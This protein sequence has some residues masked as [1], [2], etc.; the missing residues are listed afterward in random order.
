MK[1]PL[2]KRIKRE[3]KQDMGKHIALFL[4]LCLTIG[5]CSGFIVADGSM[6][7]TYND[8]FEKY[9]VED[10]HFSLSLPAD[11]K[12]ISDLESK[13]DITIYPLFYKDVET[14]DG[15]TV[16][17]Y[18]NRDKVN[19]VDVLEGELPDHNEEIAIDRL[20]A[21]NN[22]LSTGDLIRFGNKDFKI[23][24]LVALTD[25]SALFKNNTDMMLNAQ[26]FAVSVVNDNAFEDIITAIR[27]IAML[28]L[29]TTN[30]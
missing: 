10:G 19:L 5:F 14:K 25:Y 3:L 26:N 28:G 18:K 20:F 23:S 13:E 12:L 11:K 7:R 17:I 21:E 29:T 8:S 27:C 24:G 30:H 6:N 2:Y 9:N 1:N 16:R 4:F 22:Q 15:C